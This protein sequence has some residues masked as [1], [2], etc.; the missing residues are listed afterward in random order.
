VGTLVHRLF[1]RQ[2]SSDLSQTELARCVPTLLELEE[3]VDV[4]DLK[5]LSARVA[6]TYLKLRRQP[7]LQELLSSGV[8]MYE[9][10]FS[11]HQPGPPA[12]TIR[13]R[14]DCVIQRPDGSVVVV[15]V[16]TGQR[17]AEHLIQL[18]VYRQAVGKAMPECVV[19][20]RLVY[21]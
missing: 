18:D 8:A 2:L 19:D 12:H 11:L 6:E 15:E 13:G 14:I 10:P 4:S 16:K 20:A 9:L 1:Q 3:S 17:R 5:D 7:E 21:V